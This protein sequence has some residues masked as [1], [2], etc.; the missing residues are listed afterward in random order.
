MSVSPANRSSC[1]PAS[2]PSSGSTSSSTASSYEGQVFID[3]RSVGKT[4]DQSHRA[5]V[6]SFYVFGHNGCFGEA[7]HCD[8]PKEHDPFD[9]RPP[10][11]LEP[12]TRIVTAT[13]AVKKLIERDVDA[14][15]V[16]VV[17]VTEGRASAKVL[18]FEKVRLIAY[19]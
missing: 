15:K 2:T 8:I 5:Y 1:R 17:A 16:T 3:P 10:H 4:A 9:L 14:A 18:A 19:A 13:E 12:A 7:G 6:G 11:H